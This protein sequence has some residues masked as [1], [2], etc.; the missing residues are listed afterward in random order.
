MFIGGKL[1]YR[2]LRRF[3]VPRTWQSKLT[4]L[5]PPMPGKLESY[6]GR[7][8][9]RELAGRVVIDFGCRTGGDTIEIA[10]RGAARVIG[11]DIVP[12]ALA[13]ASRAAERANVAHRCTFATTTTEKADVIICIDCFEHFDDPAGVL[14]TMAQLLRPGGQVLVSF[15]PPWLHPLGGH[16]FSVF[17]WAHLLFKEGSSAE[18]VGG[19]S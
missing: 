1:G 3:P 7:S 14:R 16:S 9:W 2:A 6:W 12:Q 19:V 5:S 4:E 8:I 18:Y 15:G 10:R 11:L 17:P 13:V